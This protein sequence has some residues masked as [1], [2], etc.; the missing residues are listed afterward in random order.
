MTGKQRIYFD[1]AATTPLDPRVLEAMLPYLTTTWGNPSSIYLEAQEARRGLDGARRQV[2]EILGCKPQ[3]V[4][5]TS[6]GTESDNLALR[7]AAYGARHRGN[8]VITSQIEHHAVLHTA[9]RLEQEGFRVTYLPVDRYGF[10]DLAALE[11]AVDQETTVVSIMAANNE[12]GTIQPIDEI[13][14]IVKGKNPKA[15]VHTDFVQAAGA[16]DINVDRLGVD[17]LSLAGHKFYGPKGVGALYVRSRTPFLP[18]Q[19]GGS[20]EKDRRA[21]TENVAGIVGFATA[22]RLAYQEREARNAHCRALRDRL[23]SEVPRRVD[24]VYVTGPLDGDRRLPN[25]FSCAFGNVEGEAVL[26]AL[27]M[28]GI[29]ASSGSACTSGS[30]EPSHVLKAMGVPAEIARS[31]LRVTVGKDNTAADVD[32]F[33]EVLPAVVA[34]LRALSPRRGGERSAAVTA[35]ARAGS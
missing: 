29:A 11:A 26:L 17:M 15:A 28:E 30:L 1:H 16:L 34:R 25:N 33:L 5:F 24:G 31:S 7:G 32:R 22:L 9:E 12:V 27:D 10:V 35:W 23:L 4:I 3:E 14:R 19:L 8:H 18:Q 21:G 2:A 6:G 13:V 20:Q